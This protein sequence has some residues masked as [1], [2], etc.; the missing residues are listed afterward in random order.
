MCNRD[1]WGELSGMRSSATS[2]FA[3]SKSQGVYSRFSPNAISKSGKKMMRCYLRT[4]SWA[5][6]E[7]TSLKSWSPQTINYGVMTKSAV[8]NFQLERQAPSPPIHDL[9]LSPALDVPVLTGCISFLPISV[10]HTHQ[11]H[12][13]I[14][15]DIL[16]Y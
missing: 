9:W 10:R 4:K 16:C 13:L 15:N 14:P 5:P 7:N 1:T 12:R 2:H 6:Q 11:P 8:K 3:R